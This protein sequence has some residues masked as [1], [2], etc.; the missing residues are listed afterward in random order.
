MALWHYFGDLRASSRSI[1]IQGHQKVNP[2]VN[3][4]K[5]LFLTNVDSK[6]SVVHFFKYYCLNNPFMLLFDDERPFSS[7]VC[8]FQGQASKNMTFNK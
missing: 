8:Q 3:N 4:V 1:S 2:E 7:S 6:I 5:L